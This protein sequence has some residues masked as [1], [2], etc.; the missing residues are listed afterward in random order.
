MCASCN[1]TTKTSNTALIKPWNCKKQ[2]RNLHRDLKN[3]SMH[4]VLMIC[5]KSYKREELKG[6]VKCM[7]MPR[8][9]IWDQS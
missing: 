9:Y 4:A 6:K 2:L 7:K 8:Q 1:G 3:E 5:Y